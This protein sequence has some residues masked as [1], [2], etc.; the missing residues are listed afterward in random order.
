MIKE[1]DA[2]V[3]DELGREGAQLDG[4]E[5]QAT[6]LQSTMPAKAQHKIDESS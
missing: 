6:G 5:S 4:S 2:V 1:K 3:I